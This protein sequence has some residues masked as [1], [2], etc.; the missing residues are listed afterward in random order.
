MELFILLAALGIACG[1]GAWALL[2]T[3]PRA[4]K[5]LRDTPR[6]S[7]GNAREGQL[8]KLVGVVQKP[9]DEAESPLTRVRCAAYET[10]VVPVSGSQYPVVLESKGI[11]FQL[12]DET[13]RALIQL[14]RFRG[15]FQDEHEG[16]VNAWQPASE[17]LIAL[18]ARHGAKDP[19]LV[20]ESLSYREGVLRALDRV[21]VVGIARWEQDLDS[22]DTGFGYRDRPMRLR[23]TAPKSEPL[24]LSTEHGALKS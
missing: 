16:Q 2:G 13:G 3:R 20:G 15:L 19:K 10:L 18:L 11:D 9:A 5:I 1:M 21:A 23:V 12:E 24:L 4:E 6:T 14:D 17:E 22:C 8:V 7:V